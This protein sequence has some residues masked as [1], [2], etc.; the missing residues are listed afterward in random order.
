MTHTYEIRRFK[1]DGKITTIEKFAANPEE[2]KKRAKSICRKAPGLVHTV[3]N[4]NRRNLFH[5]R[6]EGLTS[7]LF[8]DIT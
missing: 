3:Q 7:P 1:D 5:G 2:A 8:F 6:R 4:R